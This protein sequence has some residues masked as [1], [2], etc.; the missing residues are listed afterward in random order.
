MRIRAVV[1]ALPLLAL[2]ACGTGTTDTSTTAASSVSGSAPASS[3]A[4]TLGPEVPGATVVAKPVPKGELPTASGGFG[5]K[6]TLTFPKSD[7]PPSL[8]RTI[9]KEGDG[10]ETV[11]G[12][13]LVTNYLGQIWN[14][15]VFDNSYDRKAT[16]QFQI[17]VGKVVSGWDVGLVGVKIGSRVLLSLPPADGYGAAGNSGAGIGGEDTIVFVV[18]IVDAIGAEQGGQADAKPQT[19][20]EGLPTVKGELGKMPTIT[21]GEAKPPTANKVVVLAKGTGDVVAEGGKVLA[22]YTTI[23]WDGSAQGASWPA[24]QGTGP[25]EL[26]VQTGSPLAGLVGVPIGSRVLLLIPAGTDQSGQPTP[27][28]AVV[29]DLVA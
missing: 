24:G 9:L 28:A 3:A 10:R 4:P 18:D 17:G 6:P 15:E 11:A 19:V 5:D 25:E 12:D 7:P 1:A 29:L 14:G 21:I 13:F 20:P 27:A 8:Q 16:T 23:G 2:A 26:Q 22:Q